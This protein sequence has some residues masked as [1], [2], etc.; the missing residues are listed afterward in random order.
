MSGFT[1]EDIT[2][3]ME[4]SGMDDEGDM[5]RQQMEQAQALRQPQKQYSTTIGGAL[6]GIGDVLGAV[7]QQRQTEK[8]RSQMEALSKEK[9]KRRDKLGQGLLSGMQGPA[10]P[11]QQMPNLQQQGPRLMDQQL[12]FDP[13]SFR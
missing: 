13:F 12:Q 6:G 10:A 2:Y 8:I 4:M 3:L 1:P 11:V 5:L 7:H 9:V